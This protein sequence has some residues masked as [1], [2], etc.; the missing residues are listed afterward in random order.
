M[1]LG[2]YTSLPGQRAMRP[3][4]DRGD[5]RPARR[6]RPLPRPAPHAG[7]AAVVRPRLCRVQVPQQRQDLERRRSRRSSSAWSCP[8]RCRA[9]TPTGRRTSASGSTTSLVGTWTSPGDFGDKRGIYTPRW[10]KL[11]GSQYGKLTTWRITDDGLLRRRRAR[12]PTSP[13]KQLDLAAHHSIRLRVGIDEDAKHPGGV[14]I[15]GRGF[16]NYDQDIVMRL[17]L[18]RRRRA[19][20]A[21]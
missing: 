17:Y 1:P 16:G 6:A 2:L 4:L 13:S 10:W 11:E 18:Q 7:G 12:S 14:N 5:H 3:V 15:F 8:R 21:T 20:G 9:P 19:A